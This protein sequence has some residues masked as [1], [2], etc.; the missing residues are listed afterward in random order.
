M[1]IDMNEVF[2]SRDFKK[3][4]T[5]EQYLHLKELEYQPSNLPNVG[6]HY[7]DVRAIYI[8]GHSSAFISEGSIQTFTQQPNKKIIE[9]NIPI[10]QSVELRNETSMR[11]FMILD[12]CMLLDEKDGDFTLH[13]KKGIDPDF[14]VDK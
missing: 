7:G 8:D 13:L 5:M 9:Y 11:T 10:N 12:D 1:S 14:I 3:L 4:G 6:V 2:I